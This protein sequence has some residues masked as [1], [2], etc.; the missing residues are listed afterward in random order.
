MEKIV[1]QGSLMAQLN[2]TYTGNLKFAI[3]AA[4]GLSYDDQLVISQWTSGLITKMD[5]IPIFDV[6]N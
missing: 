2:Q 1:G 6:T 5:S 4:S 3:P